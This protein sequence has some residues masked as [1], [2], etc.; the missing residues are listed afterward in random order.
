MVRLFIDRPHNVLSGLGDKVGRDMYLSAFI[1]LLVG[2]KSSS[3]VQ[4]YG[5][6]R[7][8]QRVGGFLYR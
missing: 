8:V 3:K 6:Y 2:Y 5:M 7:E 4:T 1:V